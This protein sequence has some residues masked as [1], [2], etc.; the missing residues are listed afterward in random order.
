MVGILAT[1]ALTV[2]LATASAHDHPILDA[3]AAAKPCSSGWTHAVVEG[4]HKCLRAGQFCER[5]ADGQYHAYRFHCHRYDARVDRY[6]LTEA[7][8]PQAA[9]KRKSKPK[10]RAQH[11]DAR[12]TAVTDGDTIRVRAYGAKRKY[13]RVRLIGIDTPETVDPDAPVECVGPEA[14]AAML[15][16]AFT[17]PYD[18]DGDGLLDEEGGP[19]RRVVLVTD[20][21]QDL[22]D[23]FGRLLAYVTRLGTDFGARQVRAGWAEVYV[24]E[25]R[26]RRYARFEDA[27][28]SARA[29]GRGVWGKCGGNFHQP[30][31]EPPPPPPPPPPPAPPA[32]PAP[33]PTPTPAPSCN[34]NY[35]GACLPLTGDVDCSGITAR[36][37]Y[38]VGTDVFGLDADGDGVA[39]E[40]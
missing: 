12:I 27:E 10:P 20:P 38:V 30:A 19:G 32:P 31:S 9:P 28:D 17:A 6:R 18:S 5:G 34:P 24:Y 3:Q 40:S 21:T 37:F 13:Y 11:I 36:D 35:S 16:L 4:E 33:T 39:C 29:A 25:R 8:G 1:A 7:S 2:F 23:D 22:F 14:T 15:R 26:F